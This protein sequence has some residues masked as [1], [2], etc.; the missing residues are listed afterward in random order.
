MTFRNYPY[1]IMPT[2]HGL[3]FRAIQTLTSTAFAP[4]SISSRK[5]YQ[6]CGKPSLKS[7]RSKA[8]VCNIC[9]FSCCYCSHCDQF[10]ATKDFK[11]GSKESWIFNNWLYLPCRSWS[12]SSAPLTHPIFHS[13]EFSAA[14]WICLSILRND[15]PPYIMKWT[16][17][18]FMSNS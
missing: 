4:F 10:Q 15:T 9:Q 18:L 13:D 6:W 11:T 12:S 14:L 2:Y 1:W 16:P 5:H 17:F 3:E 7:L 8:M